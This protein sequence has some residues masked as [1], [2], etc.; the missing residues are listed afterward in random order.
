MPMQ[1]RILDSA[2]RPEATAITVLYVLAGPL[3]WLTSLAALAVLG[4]W[5]CG[6]AGLTVLVE[7][8]AI[9]ACMAVMYRALDHARRG[10][11]S[12]RQRLPHFFAAGAAALGMV[13]IGA[14]AVAALLATS[15]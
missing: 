5:N 10:N 2:G 13:G 8:L 3:I 12:E 6:S 15:C 7:L 9:A 11:G 14:T 4:T 1:H